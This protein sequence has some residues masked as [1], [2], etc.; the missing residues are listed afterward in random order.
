MLKVIYQGQAVRLLEDWQLLKRA[1]ERQPG[2][3]FRLKVKR[4]VVRPVNMPRAGM[5]TWHEYPPA[6]VV[7]TIQERQQDFPQETEKVS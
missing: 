3:L 2:L 7:K 1:I 6:K 4:V 5:Y